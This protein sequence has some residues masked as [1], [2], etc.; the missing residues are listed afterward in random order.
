TERCWRFA[1]WASMTVLVG[2]P[3]KTITLTNRGARLG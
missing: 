1:Q 2:I 3:T